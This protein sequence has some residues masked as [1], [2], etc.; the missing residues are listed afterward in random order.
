MITKVMPITSTKSVNQCLIRSGTHCYAVIGQ[1]AMLL[2]IEIRE[3]CGA[4]TLPGS[5]DA[6][7]RYLPMLPGELL[8]ERGANLCQITKAD[9]MEN[10]VAFGHVSDQTL[11]LG[12][13][14]N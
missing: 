1:F 14:V 2:I 13:E 3:L 12:Y 4:L 5:G 10:N 6:L 11:P 7:S 9:F 8:C